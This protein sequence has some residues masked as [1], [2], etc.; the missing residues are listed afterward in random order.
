[1]L[2]GI[3]SLCCVVKYYVIMLAS[4]NY[5]AC[6]AALFFAGLASTALHPGVGTG[7]S[8]HVDDS[9]A[10]SVRSCSVV[11]PNIA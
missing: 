7:I 2:Y 3:L 10:M 1:M 6:V 4:F 9:E 5:S 8:P 11:E